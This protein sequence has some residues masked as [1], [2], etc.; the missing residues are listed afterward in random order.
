M[1]PGTGP[2]VFRLPKTPPQIQILIAPCM[3]LGKSAGVAKL[4][5]GL[6]PEQVRLN[7]AVGPPHASKKRQMRVF[8]RTP[9]IDPPLESTVMAPPA[10]N[11][12]EETLKR[13]PVAQDARFH[14][15]WSAAWALW[16]TCSG[17]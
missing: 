11:I 3:V 5:Q 14:L 2:L 15:V 1:G 6:H 4:G 16:K 7:R 8:C 13:R 17:G 12:G 9:L 10:K